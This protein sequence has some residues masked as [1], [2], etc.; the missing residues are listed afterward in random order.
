MSGRLRFS[1]GG[2]TVEKAI[3]AGNGARFTPGLRPSSLL[4]SIL[5]PDEPRLVSSAIDWIDVRY[6]EA[7]P[8][9]GWLRMHWILWFTLFSTVFALLLKKRFGVVI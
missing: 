9:I 6:P 8:G 7:K 2:E 3:E 4:G 1:G 5:H